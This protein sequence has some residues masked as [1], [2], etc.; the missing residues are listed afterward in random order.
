MGVSQHGADSGQPNISCGRAPLNM[1][2]VEDCQNKNRGNKCDILIN[3][4]FFSL[5]EIEQKA[6]ARCD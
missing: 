3:V 2:T 4:I 1:A 6:H 5:C